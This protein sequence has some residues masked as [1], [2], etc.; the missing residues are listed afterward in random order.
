MKEQWNDSDSTLNSE[1]FRNKMRTSI[2][3]S[4][5][6][7]HERK[8]RLSKWTQK[9]WDDKNSFFHSNETRKKIGKKSKEKWES[10][11]FRQKFSK[12]TSYSIISL[13]EKHPFFCQIEKLREDPKTGEIQVHCKNHNCKNSKEKGGWF[14]PTN[15]QIANRIFCSEHID[16]ANGSYFYCSDKCK[17]ECP[18]FGSTVNQLIRLYS[19]DNSESLYE[20]GEYQ[21]F[22]NEVIQRNIELYGKIKCELCGNINEKEL[23]IHHEKPQKTHPHMALDPDIAWILCGSNSKNKCHLK[24]GH[25]T[26]TNCSTGYLSKLVCYNA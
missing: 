8:E 18:L 7:D 22:R 21:I 1:K 2:K 20:S 5:D 6:R 11:N 3:E 24:I 26:G 10:D 12:K 13:K 4:W 17:Q 25:K 19:N 23:A 15:F 9:K 14:T 16:D